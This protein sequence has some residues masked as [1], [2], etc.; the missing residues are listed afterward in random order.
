MSGPAQYKICV[1]GELG[2]Q[3][4]A[5]FTGMAVEAEPGGTSVLWGVL[6]DQAALYGVLARIRDLGLPLL[7]VERAA[8]I[9][10]QEW[11]LS[12]PGRN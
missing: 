10:E 3:W 2:A 5:W 1:Q 11:N 7:T 9:D 8:N 6:A 12:V 4:S